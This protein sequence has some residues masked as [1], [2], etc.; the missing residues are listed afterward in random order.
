MKEKIKNLLEN[1][2]INRKAN[3]HKGTYNK[4]LIIGGS[5]QYQGAPLIVAHA[6]LRS[7]VGQVRMLIHQ[8]NI[9]NF[10]YPEVTYMEYNEEN[11]VEIINKEFKAIIFG[12]GS[13]VTPFYINLL[14]TLILKYNGNLVID[15]TGFDILKECGLDIL[16][17]N[18]KNNIFITPHIGE[19]KRLFSI[20]QNSNDVL[21]FANDCSILSSKYNIYIFLKSYNCLVTYKDSSYIIEGKSPSLAKAG[22]GDALAG[23]IGGF[24]SYIKDDYLATL[25]SAYELLLVSSLDLSSKKACG[26]LTISEIIDNIPSSIKK[27][28]DN[29]NNLINKILKK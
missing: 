3:T 25:E 20:K 27:E 15:A 22:T 7:G 21:D 16:K 26:T 8:D 14:K 28:I 5:K 11:F 19:F 6:A 2:L 23:I 13:K 12:N 17:E 4:V 18:R 9:I 29:Q 1:N 24:L 10:V